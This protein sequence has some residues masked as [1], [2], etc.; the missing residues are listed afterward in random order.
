[1]APSADLLERYA[2]LTV[3]VGANVQPG[4]LVFVD[5]TAPEHAPFVRAVVE[6]AY[7]A[8]ARY[9]DV[10]YGEPY[11]RRSLIEHAAEETLAWSAP[12]ALERVR[13]IKR[14]EA[15]LIS[16]GGDVAPELL[17][18]LDE[19]RVGRARP[20][21][22]T[23][24]R[25][26]VADRNANWVIVACPTEAWSR[27]VFGEEDV[28]R[29]WATVARC[30]RL[31]EDDPVQAWRDHVEELGARAAALNERRFDHLR[32]C[33]PGTDLTVGLF[34]RTRWLAALDETHF[35]VEHVA[36]MPTE[37]VFA[38]P[39]PSRTEG[40]V[41]ATR[42]LQ[43]AGRTIRDLRVRFA[44][45]RAVEIDASSG[46]ELLRT[47]VEADGNA[48]RLGE[49]ALVD[50]SSRVGETGLVF[51]STLFDEN[52]ACH[53]ALGDGITSSYDGPELN[54]SSIHVDFMIGGPEVEVD[55][56]TA[57]GDA[58]ALLRGNRWQL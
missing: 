36:N 46:G 22:L 53:I 56:V 51:W 15:A 13:S 34:P 26:S 52:A 11:A 23:R 4:Q 9:V 50:E 5:A 33:G 40:T 29:L 28:D 20:V 18:G 21:E 35:G 45:G 37:E 58:V 32:F 38:S 49:V 54:R 55:G 12:W 57:D 30:V 25:L 14:E 16:I 10:A 39:D 17:S 2:R 3:Q 1:M 47:Y 8:G 27:Q 7:R 48:S 31:D 44:G 6:E 43:F 41:A 19:G 42:P 24:E